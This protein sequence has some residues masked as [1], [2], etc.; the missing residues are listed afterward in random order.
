[1]FRLDHILEYWANI[2]GPLID[3]MGRLAV[4]REAEAQNRVR[5]NKTVFSIFAV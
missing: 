4:N 2:Y 5:D 3:A 1:M